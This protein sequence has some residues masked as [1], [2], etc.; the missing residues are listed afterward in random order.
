M[1][2]LVQEQ[3]G[4]TGFSTYHI[5]KFPGT[6]NLTYGCTASLSNHHETPHTEVRQ[7]TEFLPLTVDICPY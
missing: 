4:G 7:H 2:L 5:A 3:K 6:A 1:A